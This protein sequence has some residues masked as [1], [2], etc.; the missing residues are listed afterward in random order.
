V[1]TLTRFSSLAE[2]EV[3]HPTNRPPAALFPG[4]QQQ[5][6]AVRAAQRAEEI[7]A[8]CIERRRFV[9]GRVLQV[10]PDGLVVDSGYSRLLLPPLNRSWVVSETALVSRD[11]VMVEQKKPDAV[12]VGLVFLSNL[13]KRPPVKAY[14]YVA[15]RGYPAG[16]YVYSPVAGIQKKVR[17]FCAN[18]KQAVQLNMD[19]GPE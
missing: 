18:L 6:E 9:A 1:L 10:L 14:D 13:P 17:R 19:R 15:I 3:A 8:S 12:C 2:I 11:A 5:A 4:F 16:E 7:R